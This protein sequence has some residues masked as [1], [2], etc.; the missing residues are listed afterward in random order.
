MK[1]EAVLFDLDNTLI[2]FNETIFFKE[3]MKNLS[4]HFTDLMT[5]QDFTQR[6]FQATLVM[7]DNNGEQTNAE[8]F[9]N[10]FGNGADADKDELWQRFIFF[11][12]NNFEQL[13]PLMTPIKKAPEVMLNIQQKGLKIVIATNPMFPMNVQLDRLR[14]AGLEDFPYELITSAD[15][16]S[17]CK[18][19]L[20]YYNQI[21]D[22]IGVAPQNSLM[23]GNDPFND[24]IASKIGM[25]TYLTTDS[26]HISIEMS[27]ELA[28][29]AELEMPPP[30]YK[31]SLTDLI[32][33]IEGLI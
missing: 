19:N 13:R 28:K 15:N 17:F 22:K 18:P 26:D 23:V 9:I 32:K 27:R 20:E 3:Y 12:E 31:G 8:L 7:V 25:K 33:V 6:L 30:D 10:S 14:W 29:N 24:M 5:I 1:L 11:Y 4:A 16:T 21:C 2:L